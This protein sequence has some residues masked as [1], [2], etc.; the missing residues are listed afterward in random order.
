MQRD[1]GLVGFLDPLALPLPA[2]RGLAGP[3]GD[4]S[5]RSFGTRKGKCG[6]TEDL[7]AA[8]NIAIMPAVKLFEGATCPRT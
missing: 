5:G 7:V 6:G 8:N 3:H 4:A 2:A 1:F